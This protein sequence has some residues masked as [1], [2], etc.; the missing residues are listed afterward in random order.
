[1]LLDMC[2]LAV[3]GWLLEGGRVEEGRE[4]GSRKGGREGR[5]R[6]GGR[7]KEGRE[8]VVSLVLL[9]SLSHG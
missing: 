2:T 6:E 9:T 8:G 7:V 4:G 5:G 1:M 3:S